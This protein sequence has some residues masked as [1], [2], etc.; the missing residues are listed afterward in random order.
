MIEERITSRKNPLLVQVKKLLSSRSE[1]LR[2]GLFVCDG[3]KLLAEAAQYAPKTL[4]TVILADGVET[5]PLP[6][7]VRVVRVPG[8]VMESISPMRSPQGAVFLCRLPQAASLSVRPGMLILDG[9]QDPGNVGTILRTADAMDIPVVLTEGS[10]DPYSW[11]AARATMGAI[12]RRPPSIANWQSVVNACKAAQIPL[13]AAALTETAK[14]IRDSHLANCA[15]I[16]GSEGQGIR[17]ELMEVCDE[18]L[19]IPMNAQCESLNAA[20]A[21]AIVLWEMRRNK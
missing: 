8:D 17:K 21:A 4:H 20:V 3:T 13:A 10:A 7:S 16:I 9:V 1:R 14:D 12:F 11:K 19:I 6:A 5:C 15:V 2:Q 18:T